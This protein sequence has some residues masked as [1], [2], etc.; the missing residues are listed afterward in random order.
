MYYKS[1]QVCANK[2]YKK[3]FTRGQEKVIKVYNDYTRMISGAKS[4]SV[5]REWIKIL[6]LKTMLQKLAIVLAQVKTGDISSSLLNKI[7]HM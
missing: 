5:Q 6:T 7:R 4:K 1:D 2:R 3:I